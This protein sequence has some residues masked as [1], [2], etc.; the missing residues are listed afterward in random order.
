MLMVR[1]NVLVRGAI[2]TSDRSGPTLL[3][4]STQD[5]TEKIFEHFSNS[6]AGQANLAEQIVDRRDNHGNLTMLQP[7]YNVVYYVV[8]EVVC[9]TFGA[10]RLDPQKIENAGIVI[11][12][13]NGTT[14]E[15]WTSE[16]DEIRGWLPL[17]DADQDPDPQYRTYPSAGHE[18]LDRH[19]FALRG[20][21]NTQEG[22]DML[23]VAPSRVCEAAGKTLVFGSLP[24]SS[25]ERT[26][27]T[28][29]ALVYE[30][31]ELNDLRDHIPRYF[32]AG[33]SRIFPSSIRGREVNMVDDAEDLTKFLGLLQQVKF[34]FNAFGTSPESL[35]IYAALNTILLQT[36]GDPIPAGDFL[37]QAADV[38]LD[39][40]ATT[41]SPTPS[42]RI[43]L[44][45]PAIDQAKE[46]QLFELFV[47]SL[48][49]S[50]SGFAQGE[51]RYS[52][53]NDLYQARAFVRIRKE[54]DC[55]LETI[56]SDYS[57]KFRIAPWHE[58]GDT[59]PIRIAVPDPFDPDFI[60]NAKPNVAFDMPP[61]LFNFLES[62]V[63]EKILDGMKTG[64]SGG[65]GL[66]WICGF[67]LSIIFVIAF[68]IM[69]VFLLLL[70]IVFFWK[71]FIKICIP[72][73]KSK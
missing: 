66:G 24:I 72:F 70:N 25:V 63:P 37:K 21:A 49:K 29:D 35:A 61:R 5:P 16:S 69:F 60:K 34:E 17:V 2:G 36:D 71:F 67:N 26:Q 47:A 23:F 13:V 41:K 22:S 12:R 43:P 20:D 46:D 58:S 31:S 33:G 14:H 48:K 30:E 62:M 8:A 6:E 53:A 15:A 28:P 57:E 38:L 56:W 1:H 27:F 39:P 64:S 51:S 55:P 10:P 73:P 11:R 40:E 7:I 65:L 18:V 44:N 19:L 4:L 9:D 3:E 32:K 54:P 68:I 52:G 59:A 45:W 50:V 42:V